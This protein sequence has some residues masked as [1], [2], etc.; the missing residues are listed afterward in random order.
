[1]IM[2]L[3]LGC[4]ISMQAIAAFMAFRIGRLTGRRVS[5]SMIFM[6]IRRLVPLYRVLIG[7]TTFRLDPTAEMIALLISILML[8]GIMGIA[9]FF[10]TIKRSA[11]GLREF[12]RQQEALLNNIPDIAWLKDKEGIFI[13]VN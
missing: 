5:W 8:G 10:L 4:S 12:Q 11:E 7:D 3:M 9:P 6:A 1:M 2:T 13:A